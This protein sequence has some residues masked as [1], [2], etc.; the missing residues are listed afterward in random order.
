MK[1]SVYEHIHLFRWIKITL[2]FKFQAQ[3]SKLKLYTHAQ[4]IFVLS[5]LITKNYFYVSS[6]IFM[7]L[8]SPPHQAYDGPSSKSLANKV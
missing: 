1:S 2:S 3:S 8:N 6:L 5:V 7:S 4:A